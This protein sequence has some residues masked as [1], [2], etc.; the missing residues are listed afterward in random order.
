MY[1][2]L[3]GVTLSSEDDVHWFINGV[4][5]ILKP[6][7]D[8]KGKINM[9]VN[10]EGFDLSNHLEDLY[11]TLVESLQSDMYLTAKRYTGH[12]FQRARLSTRLG[13][14]E[15]NPDLLFDLFD[16]KRDDKLSVEEL[17]EGFLSNFKMSLTPEHIK[18]FVGESNGSVVDREAFVKGVKAVLQDVN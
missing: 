3:F 5:D 7:V 14:S 18:E 9:V 11:G 12:A 10:Y 1:L 15:W 8:P 13:A 17:R 4:R 6:Y 16:T 2:D